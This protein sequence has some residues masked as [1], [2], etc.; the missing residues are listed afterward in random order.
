M[1]LHIVLYAITC[2]IIPLSCPFSLFS[3]KNREE[4]TRIEQVYLLLGG[5]SYEDTDLILYL[6]TNHSCNYSDFNALLYNGS[7]HVNITIQP[8]GDASVCSILLPK[9]YFKGI[10]Y[11]LQIRNYLESR[12]L[13]LWIIV[14]DPIFYRFSDNFIEKHKTNLTNN[15]FQYAPIPEVLLGYDHSKLS[16]FI[17]PVAD[18]AFQI[19]ISEFLN[20][21]NPLFITEVQQLDHFSMLLRSDRK[22][23]LLSEKVLKFEFN[24]EFRLIRANPN[25]LVLINESDVITIHETSA[26]QTTYFNLT[27]LLIEWKVTITRIMDAKLFS[28]RLMLLITSNNHSKIISLNIS[29]PTSSKFKLLDEVWTGEKEQF[30]TNFFINPHSHAIF[31]IGKNVLQITHSLE[32]QTF[33][34]PQIKAILFQEVSCLIYT[35]NSS[36]YVEDCHVSLSNP[37][38]L[39]YN[40]TIFLGTWGQPFVYVSNTKFSQLLIEKSNCLVRKLEFIPSYLP[41]ARVIDR[42]ETFT[43]RVIVLKSEFRISDL[44]FEMLHF[45]PNLIKLS[46]QSEL[47]RTHL[48]LI[49]AYKPVG[50]TNIRIAPKCTSRLPLHRKSLNI[51]VACPSQYKLTLISPSHKT[52]YYSLPPN[53]R[54]PSS[55]GHMVPTSTNIYNYYPELKIKPNVHYKSVPFILRHCLNF[56][57]RKDC[58]CNE[59]KKNSEDISLSE[60]K[61]R[62]RV[63][64]YHHPLHIQTSLS[65]ED[66]SVIQHIDDWKIPFSLI[67]INNRSDFIHSNISDS[68]YIHF[69][70]SGLFHFEAKFKPNSIW[71][72]C[73]F[74]SQVQIF[75]INAPLL[76]EVEHTV[77]MITAT[78]FG[79]GMGIACLMLKDVKKCKRIKSNNI[80]YLKQI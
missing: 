13:I 61:E 47:N 15:T 3:S 32:T 75:V 59:E 7:F 52:N 12:I 70:G 41:S 27:D 35:H 65:W 39:N 1:I 28:D 67:E 38:I 77:T 54:P 71:T 24:F 46:Q 42:W 60:C 44:I 9:H 30:A 63:H 53:Y 56:K 78:L 43:I 14:N 29:L 23:F 8:D 5:S 74:K 21:S 69:L 36:Y 37:H 45:G 19:D 73:F 79:L 33:D 57:S 26:N 6:D 16:V 51:K 76:K 40:T 50:A 58:K 31:T 66:G 17:S 18:E 4:S 2:I 25:L 80:S 68:H 22:V 49:L 55:Y 10:K 11:Y 48:E 64:Q 72:Y 62:V 20:I 34:I